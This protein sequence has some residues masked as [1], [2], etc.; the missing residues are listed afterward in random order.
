LV[1]DRAGDEQG[2]V[3]LGAQPLRQLGGALNEGAEAILLNDVVFGFDVE[4]G[5]ERMAT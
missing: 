5:I 3:A 4:V 2:I 1:G